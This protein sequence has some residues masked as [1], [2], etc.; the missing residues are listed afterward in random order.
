MTGNEMRKRFGLGATVATLVVAGFLGGS[1]PA[2]AF[3][4]RP[5]TFDPLL[6][7]VGLGRDDAEKPQIDFRERPK[8]VVPKGDDLP[9]PQ[10]GGAGHAA[11]WPV[12]QDVKRR[13]AAAEAARAPRVISL[14]ERTT[15]TPAELQRGRSDEKPTATELCDTRYGGVPDCSALTPVDKLKRVF[16]LGGAPVDPNKVTPG[17]EPTREYLTEPP[18]GYRAATRTVEVR[19]RAPNRAYESPSASDYARGVDPNKDN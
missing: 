8:L 17:A 7:I 13:R 11:N 1:V 10:S 5:S 14:N 18:A 6:N 15:L 19:Q 12:D 16:S 2:R 3:D 4:D 9:P